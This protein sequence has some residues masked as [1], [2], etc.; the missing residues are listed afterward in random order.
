MELLSS[1]LNNAFLSLWF[2][3]G[4]IIEIF[5]EYLKFNQGLFKVLDEDC[6]QIWSFKILQS[7]W[8]RLE[9]KIF[10]TIFIKEI[11]EILKKN[12]TRFWHK[13]VTEKITGNLDSTIKQLIILS[14]KHPLFLLLSIIEAA[15]HKLLKGNLE[16][17]RHTS[18]F[19][20]LL[21]AHLYLSISC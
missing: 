8:K 7:Y 13:S 15:S 6:Y 14:S 2:P 21:C 16:R 17:V 3:H 5:G 19:N 18:N 10:L 12:V 1:N 20:G 9:D 4:N 11:I